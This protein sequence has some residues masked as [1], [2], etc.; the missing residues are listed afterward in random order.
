MTRMDTSQQ[1][2]TL[3]RAVLRLGLLVAGLLVIAALAAGC[4]ESDAEKAQNQVC[5]ARDDLNKQVNELAG[6]TPATATT[7]GVQDEPRRDPERP[8]RHQGRTGRPQRRPKAGG[9]VGQPGVRLPGPGGRERSRYE[10][11]R[12]R[13]KGPAA[14]RGHTTAN[15]LPADLRED[16]LRLIGNGEALPQV[17]LPRFA[18]F[19]VRNPADGR[20]G[21]RWSAQGSKRVFPAIAACCGIL[22][23]ASDGTRTRDL[24]RDRPAL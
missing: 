6:L 5:D 21:L 16:R 11:L 4:G 20:A 2:F 13:G 14:E 23:S 18:T 22:L 9:R 15:R 19:M 3:S 24:R 12:Q 10:P 8:Q 17:P 7:E 1:A